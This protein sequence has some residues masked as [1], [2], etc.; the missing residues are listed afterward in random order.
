M[1]TQNLLCMNCRVIPMVF[2]YKGKSTYV[3]KCHEI[4]FHTLMIFICTFLWIFIMLWIFFIKITTSLWKF[5]NSQIV[6]DFSLGFHGH[7][8]WQWY[9]LH[10][11]DVFGKYF[12]CIWCI[13]V[14]DR[15]SPVIFHFEVHSY[16]TVGHTVCFTTREACHEYVIS[17][18]WTVTVLWKLICGILCIASWFMKCLLHKNFFIFPWPCRVFMGNVATYWMVKFMG[19][20]GT[21]GSIS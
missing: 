16:H 14:A 18:L 3:W 2:I 11:E 17:L 21:F 15:Q 10:W 13:H 12:H 19:K 8:L 4:T 7:V 1:K 20:T 9:A 6:H 5:D